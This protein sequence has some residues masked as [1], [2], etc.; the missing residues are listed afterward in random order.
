[1]SKQKW[2]YI[3]I[4]LIALLLGSFT[5]IRWTES[6]D[7]P[8]YMRLHFDT[9]VSE[10]KLGDFKQDY[11]IIDFWASWCQPCVKS[12]PYY[13]Q[14]FNQLPTDKFA[15]IAVNLDSEADSAKQFL[16]DL[17]LT[18]TNVFYD[19]NGQLQQALNITGLPTLVI[20]NKQQ[21]V[22]RLLGY[23]EKHKT[24]LDSILTEL[25]QP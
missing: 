7:E 9:N 18:Q 15:Y 25:S 6:H 3:G 19:P 2:F 23:N 13:E 4:A 17:N 10:T 11:L 8:G 1:M 20:L 16:A 5:A 21:E 22:T 14:R 24:K 12:L